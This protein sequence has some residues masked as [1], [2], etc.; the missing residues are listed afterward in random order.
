VKSALSLCLIVR[1]DPTGL[2]RCLESARPYVEEICIVDTGSRDETPAVAREFADKFEV[3]EG[4]NDEAGKIADFGAAR[5]RSFALASHN[6][7]LWLDSDDELIG[8]EH[9]AGLVAP[10][11]QDD[12]LM[13]AYDYTQDAQGRS[14][15]LHWRE[16]VVDRRSFVWVGQVHEV[17]APVGHGIAC[18][19]CA[20]E[21]ETLRMALAAPIRHTR[22]I[23]VEEV[24]VIHHRQRLNKPSDPERNLR[25]LDRHHARHGDLSVRDLYYRGLELGYQGRLRESIASHKLYVSR[26]GWDDEKALATLEIARHHAAL[27]EY[28]EARDWAGQALQVRETWAEPYFLLGQCWYHLAQAAKGVERVRNW[29]RV[30]FWIRTGLALPPTRTILW[31]DPTGRMQVHLY[32]NVA[33]FELGDV[34]GALESCEAASELGDTGI[35]RNALLYREK[36]ARAAHEESTAELT[37]LGHMSVAAAKVARDI[38]AGQYSVASSS[39]GDTDVIIYTGPALERWNPDTIERRGPMG[40][41]ELMAWQMARGLRARG[42]SVRL[43]GDC[44]GMEG[45]WDGVQ[46]V[47]YHAAQGLRCRLLIA[48]RQAD[49]LDVIGHDRSWLWVHDITAGDALTP[50]RAQR[51][52]R[53]MVLSRWHEQAMLSH[54]PWLADGSLTVTRNGIDLGLFAR[55]DVPR[56]QARAMCTSSPD[57]YLPAL[58]DLWPEIR[59]RVPEAEFHCYYGFNNW[60]NSAEMAGDRSQLATIAALEKRLDS[61][62]ELGV[63]VHG[64]VNQREL[65]EA[66][67]SSGAILYPTW[68]SETSCLSAMQARA[69]GCHVVTSPIAALTETL[70]GY[71]H[72]TLVD[73]EYMSGDYRA[74]FVDAAVRALTQPAEADAAAFDIDTLVLQW[75]E[76]IRQEGPV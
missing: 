32:L 49:A 48:S 73:S 29:E 46:F 17:L 24:R 22:P 55:T 20:L 6:R 39:A 31:V 69:A 7:V 45:T 68:F 76:M 61:M 34:R 41:S 58:L 65:A 54:Y 16:R 38:V 40:G 4:C 11:E 37:R 35:I 14:V 21:D 25:I 51:L 8:G 75:D 57:R 26:S 47:D 67:L 56:K 19:A 60:R 10:L 27:G 23:Q 3:W 5:R 66:F 12:Y 15:C 72:A 62:R 63:V 74:Q 52:E 44:L 1:D 36:L 43:V 33:L 28:A 64:R 13:L 70:A 9:L 2:R 59:Q 30:V 50:E 71:K 42:H 18:P 53:I